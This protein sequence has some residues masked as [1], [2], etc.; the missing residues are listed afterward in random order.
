MSAAVNISA[1]AAMPAAARPTAVLSS[2]D[3]AFPSILRSDATVT[4]FLRPI[5]GMLEDSSVNELCVNQPGEVF[6]ERA[7]VW[8]RHEIPEFTFR[9]CQSLA[10]AIATLTGQHTNEQ[11]PLL[12]A[13]LSTGERVQIVQPSATPA[14]QIGVCIRKPSM[15]VRRLEDFAAQGLFER[16]REVRCELEPFER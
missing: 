3:R 14:D 8:Q 12:S 16:V 15:Q 6:V 1:T 7:G 4:E 5:R 9:H 13:A 11:N 2:V 10:T